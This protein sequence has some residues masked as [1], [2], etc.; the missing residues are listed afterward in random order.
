[1]HY[2]DTI[3]NHVD[4]FFKFS[5]IVKF[6]RVDSNHYGKRKFHNHR[7]VSILGTKEQT[8]VTLESFEISNRKQYAKDCIV[9]ILQ[10][11]KETIADA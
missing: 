8:S 9:L 3:Q 4:F 11:I 7:D 6:L 10:H 1:M 2:K 5:H